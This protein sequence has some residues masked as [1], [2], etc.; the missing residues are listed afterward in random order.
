M[1]NTY[2][3]LAQL[4]STSTGLVTL[5][6]GSANRQYIISG[7][8]VCNRSTAENTFRL[9]V[10]PNGSTNAVPQYLHW[11]QAV[12]GNDTYLVNVP[13]TMDA[14][15]VIRVKQFSTGFSYNVFGAEISS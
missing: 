8:T 6:T 3:V 7:I 4:A 12:P 14:S 1:A 2:K 10:A 9:S 5:F 11:E 13:I 15:D